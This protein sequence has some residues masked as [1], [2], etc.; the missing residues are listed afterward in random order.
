MV[1]PISSVVA[2]ISI[3]NPTSTMRSPALDPTIP[4]PRIF[5]VFFSIINF[6]I[7][8]DL[9]KANDLPLAAQGKTPFS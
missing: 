7:P 3:A 9:P 4:A 8:S 1:S 6:V 2:S 5:L